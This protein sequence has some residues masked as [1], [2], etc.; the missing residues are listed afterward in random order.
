MRV[1]SA[2]VGLVFTLLLT[3]SPIT[4]QTYR[5]PSAAIGFGGSALIAGEQVLIGRPGTLIGFPIPASH[6]GAVHVFRRAGGGL[7][8]TGMFAPKD[9]ALGDGFG[10]ALAAEGNLLAV[11]APGAAG[12]GAVY[13][14]ERG[15]GGKWT[16][17]ARLTLK[18]GTETDRLGAAVALRGGVLLAGAP[19]REGERG[20]VLI[21]RKGRSVADWGSATVLQGSG[22]AA[23]DWFGAA[24]AYDGQRALVGAP[25]RW[26]AD[27]TGWKPGQAFVFRPSQRGPWTEE[28]RLAPD[29]SERVSSIGVAVLLDGADA[30]VGAPRADSMAGAVVRYRRQGNAWTAVGR[31][32]QDSV[33]RPAGFGAALARDGNDLLVGAP[34][35]AQNAGAVHVFR[36]AGSGD[37]KVAQ[38]LVTP[39]AGYSTRLGAAIAAGSGLAVAGAPLAYFFEGTGL[40][41]QREGATGRW[42]ETATVSDTIS[43]S[44]PAVSGGEVKCESGR[45]KGFDCKDAD[46]VAFIPKHAMGAKRGTLLND[47]WGWTDSTTNREFA[48]VGRTDGTSFVEVTDPANPKY[49]G[50]L[51][52][53]E[54]A[55]PNIWRDMK[56][57]KNHA[58]IV[59]DGSGPHGMQVFDLT[60]LRN[61]TTPQT[62]RETAHYARI[63]SAHNI[64]IN[65]KTGFAYT[66]GNSMG[67]E[68]CGGALHMV[69]IRDPVNPKFAGCYADPALGLSRTGST[70]DAQCVTYHGPDTRYHGREICFNSSETALGIADVTDKSR[71]RTI[72][73]AAYPNVAYA[74]QGWLTDDHKHFYLDDEGDELAGTAPKTRTVVFDLTDLE[75]PVVA[76]EF[77]GTTAASDH[78]LY[79]KGRYMYQSNYVAGL[80]V[81]DIQDPVNPVEVGHFD[82]VPVGDNLP[83]FSGSWSNY[84]YFRSGVVA[85]TSMREGLFLV[86]YQPTPVVP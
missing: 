45:A 54:G 63:N 76:K 1:V 64:V 21:Y 34:M 25:G 14:Y 53:H 22:T 11:G 86:R 61:V 43:T 58:Y 2:C 68:T 7:T 10:T 39:P 3:P 77:Y 80:R 56:V 65:E 16:E 46:L 84:P 42:R 15:T 36:R 9:G 70:H 24:I 60:Q 81:V 19:G 17:R 73:I 66:V 33:A 82:T 30:L 35:S 41:Y 48:I 83:G 29:S 62:F 55:R 31:L 79:V 59:A 72:S 71:P 23:N 28:G 52:M 50:D 67:G 51:P 57:Y 32:G 12:G 78:N 49:L 4:A 75:D 74:H 37:W 69:D 27:S 8:E 38:K 5:D 18:D 40:V 13:V 20:A 47:L 44:L 26:T 85:A 6:A